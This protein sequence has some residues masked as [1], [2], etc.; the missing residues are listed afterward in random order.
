MSSEKASGMLGNFVCAHLANLSVLHLCT[1][2]SFVPH[3]HHHSVCQ[4]RAQQSYMNSVQ[5]IQPLKQKPRPAQDS[6]CNEQVR[7]NHHNPSP[8]HPSLSIITASGNDIIVLVAE[9]Y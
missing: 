9:A 1:Q 6:L 3:V 8:L 7:H 4:A 5:M 2:Q